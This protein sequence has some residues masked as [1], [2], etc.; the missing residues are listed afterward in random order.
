MQ[1]PCDKA[2]AA[3]PGGVRRTIGA[4]VVLFVFLGSA[5]PATAQE[6]RLFQIEGI[7]GFFELGFL[8]NID[9]RLRTNSSDSNFSR[10]ELSQLLDLRTHGY[11]YHPR[12]LTFVGGL[13][14]EGIE[15]LAGE[16]S[17]R[18][19]V[20]GDYR[21]DFFSRHRNSLSLFGRYKESNVTRPFAPSYD[22]TNSAYGATFFQK[23]GW[24]PFDLTY[25]HREESG[26]L[27]GNLDNSTD[28]VIFSGRYQFTE[29][30]IGDLD[31]QL[32]FDEI[33]GRDVRRQR[34]S[35]NNRSYFGDGI[36]KRL[37]TNVR[38]YEEKDGLQLYDAS[39]GTGFT[40]RH[41]DDLTTRYALDGRWNET[42]AQSSTHL[43]PNLALSHQLYNSLRSD[44]RLFGFVDGSSFR[45][46]Y[47]YGGSIAENYTKILGDWG[48][49]N[50]SVAPRVA[51][52]YDRPDAATGFVFREEHQMVGFDPVRL[53][54]TD[55]IESSIVVTDQAGIPYD[56]GPLG[57]YTVEQLGGGFETELRRV[58]GSDILDG[59]V[60]RVAYEYELPGFGDSDLLSV[61]VSAHTS[62]SL[63]EHLSVFGR[64]EQ[65][66]THVLSGS[67]S[68]IRLN[69]YN[70][71]STGLEFNWPWFSA[72][73]EFID[74]DATFGRFR[75]YSGETSFFTY[76]TDTWHARLNAGYIYRDYLD[77]T[78][79]DLSRV[80][81]SAS[82]GTRLFLRGL[83]EAEGSWMRGRWDGPS[84]DAND[85]DL[86][87]VKLKY[88]WWY[89]KVEVKFETGFIQIIRPAEQS[90]GYLVDLR[91]RR[92]F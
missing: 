3:L 33:Q 53:D 40:W 16:T 76:G 31:Y 43:S 85:I 88:S 32:N 19:L 80:T 50:M 18:L 86:M 22:V 58:P 38:F 70:R 13:Q 87:H 66:N 42:D 59:E 36:D 68:D 5:M 65:F 49:L 30:S 69:N 63:V 44:F 92:V 75:G 78:G 15:G 74:N 55:I 7:D 83:L 81:M 77:D 67:D 34:V 35:A 14:L 2:G 61:G 91:V 17:T 27:R 48:R 64:Y 62:L 41:N 82:A 60:V 20:G 47:Q 39:G 26:G 11:F 57:D 84:G 73:A 45:K 23:W 51:V 25:Q 10:I 71:Y 89:G 12:L 1:N 6:V 37:F 28:E 4:V 90:S 52:T 8:T 9:D 56:P 46:R 29:E 79:E 24:V 21:F 54:Q 72:K